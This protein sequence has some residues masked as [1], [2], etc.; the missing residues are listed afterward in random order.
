MKVLMLSK[1]CHVAA[2]RQKLEEL[3]QT[4]QVDL[5]LVVPPFWRVKKGW[6]LTLE[7]GHTQGYR[8][9]VANPLFNGS[10]HFHFYPSLPRLLEEVKPHILHIDEEPYDMVTLHALWHARRWKAKTLFF[11]WQNINRLFPPPFF[12]FER[13]SFRHVDAA[14]AGNADAARVLGQKGFTK[15]IF[16]IPQFGVDETTYARQPQD[17]GQDRIFRLAYVGRLVPE[18]GVQVLLDAL[19]SLEGS[20]ALEILGDGPYKPALEGKI[21]GLNLESQVTILAPIPSQEMPTYLSRLDALVLPSLTRPHWKEQFG[22]VLVEAMACQVPVVGSDCGEIPN[23]IGQAGLVFPEG[24]ATALRQHLRRLMAQPS[25][26]TELGRRGRERVLA[27][28]TQRHIA[29]Q[30]HEVYLS[31]LLAK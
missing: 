19:A 29:Q 26:R 4:F 23:V 13:Y 16:V 5:T 17:R 25:L 30:T 11:T 10:F 7:P 18:K 3:A 8:M 20:W 15:R 12:F 27:L 24:D 6:R 2:Y 31:L 21:K 28:Y 14:I 22:R 1:A 9:V